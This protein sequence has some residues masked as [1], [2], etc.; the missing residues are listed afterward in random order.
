[1][2][3]AP[4]EY[5]KGLP[6][7]TIAACVLIP[8]NDLYLIIRKRSTQQW[9]LPGGIVES[10]ESPMAGAIRE[11]LEETG[12]RPSIE[13][14]YHVYYSEPVI[15]EK[16][17]YGDSIHLIFKAKPIT[18]DQLDQICFPDQEADEY[19]WVAL[20]EVA[21]FVQSNLGKAIISASG[22]NLYSVWKRTLDSLMN[23]D[24]YYRSK[25]DSL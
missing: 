24:E 9:T 17:S 25:K 23:E 15:G 6:R 11:C 3:T 2:I 5:Y 10:G 19:Q 20:D 14:L 1:M 21:S 22:G 13:G 12:I 4:E 18:A 7:K 8:H 16:I